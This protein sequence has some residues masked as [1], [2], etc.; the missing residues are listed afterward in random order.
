M[1]LRGKGKAENRTYILNGK[2]GIYRI[3]NLKTISFY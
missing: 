3:V 1:T 2:G